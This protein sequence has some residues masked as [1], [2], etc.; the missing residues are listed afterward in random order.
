MAALQ[1]L[2]SDKALQYVFSLLE[3]DSAGKAIETGKQFDIPVE[4][5]ANL[6]AQE[7]SLKMLRVYSQ[8]VLSMGPSARG[9]VANGRLLG[10]LD[11]E[12]GFNQEDFA[13]LERFS[14]TTYGDKIQKVLNMDDDDEAPGELLHYFF[15]MGQNVW[16]KWDRLV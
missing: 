12:E 5:K 6:P 8:R 16:V 7:I 2:P 3:D 13:L 9:V 11:D 10:P 15:Y 4:L 1:T 14:L